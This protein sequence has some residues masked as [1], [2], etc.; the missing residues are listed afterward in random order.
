MSRGRRSTVSVPSE[1]HPVPRTK[2]GMRWIWGLLKAAIALG[3]GSAALVA[4]VLGAW[5]LYGNVVITI[6]MQDQKAALTLPQEL[7]AVAEVSNNL[8]VAMNGMIRTAVPFKQSMVVPFNGRY[9]FDVDMNAQVPVEFTVDYDG[10]LPIDTAADVTIRTGIN[11]KNLKALRNL[12]IQTSLPLKFPLPVKLKIPVSDTID[13][14]YSGP[15]AADIQQDVKTQVD[16]VLR[17][18]L[19][20]NQTVTTP[21][22]AAL[23]LTVRPEQDAVKLLISELIIPLQPLD[24]LGFKLADESENYERLDDP[25]GPAKAP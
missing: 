4:G 22:T 2:A 8:D 1:T 20:V 25:W 14:S 16:T 6:H 21:V 12:E 5:W 3:V 11:Y 23:P 17:T 18:T 24:M 13:L 7:H 19:P 10:I 15:L 9:D